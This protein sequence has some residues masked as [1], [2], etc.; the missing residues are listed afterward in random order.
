MSDR[1]RRLFE[2]TVRGNITDICVAVARH[3]DREAV[4]ALLDL[5]FL[6]EESLLAAIE[7]VGELKDAAMTGYLLEVKRLRFG[8]SAMDFD[9]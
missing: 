9:L 7:V 1:A 2:R 3:D 6:D 5:G 4:D 8:G